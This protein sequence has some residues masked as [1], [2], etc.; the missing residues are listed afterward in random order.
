MFEQIMASNP[1]FMENIKKVVPASVGNDP[2]AI[3]RF[4]ND[5]PAGE[6][7][8]FGIAA[9]V[10][11]LGRSQY[12]NIVNTTANWA[13]AVS[14]GVQIQSDIPNATGLDMLFGNG[15]LTGKIGADLAIDVSRRLMGE[16][17]DPKNLYG[18][19]QESVS[20]FAN[21]I[22]SN[23]STG[24]VARMRGV[25]AMEALNDRILEARRSGDAVQEKFLTDRQTEL[26][27]QGVDQGSDANA[28]KRIS[29]MAGMVG[30]SDREKDALSGISEQTT[31]LELV[32]ET[33]EMISKL[34]EKTVKA[35]AKLG[36]VFQGLS[37]P[38]LQM[39]LRTITGTADPTR[40]L[41][42]ITKLIDTSKAFGLD[43]RA[44]LE[45]L[46]NPIAMQTGMSMLA[47]AY[48]GSRPGL[49]LTDTTAQNAG[50][51]SSIARQAALGAM[52]SSHI[53]A[54]AG[55]LFNQMEYV[56]NAAEAGKRGMMSQDAMTGNILTTAMGYADQMGDK[57]LG[58]Q[59]RSVISNMGSS[60]K[61]R[62]R[63]MQ[64]VRDIM[65]RAGAPD[66]TRLAQTSEGRAFASMMSDE[67]S[68]ALASATK[69]GML[70]GVSRF[71]ASNK[72]SSLRKIMGSAAGAEMAAGAI[73]GELGLEGLAA[74]EGAAAKGEDASAFL[75]KYV[76]GDKLGMVSKAL[77]GP[78]GKINQ[79]LVTE[80]R[81]GAM[82]FAPK[83]NQHSRYTQGKAGEVM[84]ANWNPSV[85]SNFGQ[86]G[87]TLGNILKYMIT[88]NGDKIFSDDQYRMS[89]LMGLGL[90]PATLGTTKIAD[91]RNMGAADL[92]NLENMVGD[93]NF[94]IA[95]KMGFRNMTDLSNA[96][97]K[98]PKL[99]AKMLGAFQTAGLEFVRDEDKNGVTVANKKTI[100]SSENTA[101]LKAAQQAA[102]YAS[103]VG[104]DPSN[105]DVVFNSILSG[106]GIAA[107]SKQAEALNMGGLFK[108]NG[109]ATEDFLNASYKKGESATIA[110]DRWGSMGEQLNKLNSLNK[111]Q[112]AAYKEMD[113]KSGGQLMKGW[114]NARDAL[115]SA[116]KAIAKGDL[117]GIKIDGKETI[118]PMKI[119][120]RLDELN[121]LIGDMQG[122]A[123]NTPQIQV[124]G[125]LIV[126][127]KIRE[128]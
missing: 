18:R 6:M 82:P 103:L 88:P 112:L 4:L 40:Q 25:T 75:K 110:G 114:L 38:A 57:A 17:L 12:G 60:P 77:I 106:K 116:Q 89:A 39:K 5:T 42:T 68:E 56:S 96:A 11:Q 9:L 87:G 128:P 16:N 124:S 95:E 74:L 27:R 63:G 83:I 85:G 33:T 53:P 123:T 64:Q 58:D 73:F 91:Y 111:E 97:K 43:P 98:D 69:G 92:A 71:F 2:V 1:M 8:K 49:R 76:S 120:S 118:D 109:S 50:I 65:K 47:G 22:M 127:G 62:I 21:T 70:K 36:D 86:G 54:P 14:R 26:K 119:Q 20:M 104:M 30:I 93:K 15:R 46:T 51:Y 52:T 80:L 37:D 29:D 34:T 122:A 67:S 13:Q 81:K 7:G 55:T 101:R 44:T 59:L 79:S 66:V 107:D 125:D 48:G 3:S 28:R 102:I 105:R 23:V 117:A 108:I 72:D 115:S 19:T 31:K 100:R 32:D 84:L 78:D 90:D 35:V 24:P 10:Q 113:N 45:D 126:S 99:A 41:D 94:K 121:K 61:D